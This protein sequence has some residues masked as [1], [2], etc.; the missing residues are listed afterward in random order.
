MNNILDLTLTLRNF[1]E[2]F[3][4]QPIRPKRLISREA[5]LFQNKFFTLA[6]GGRQLLITIRV[7]YGD[8]QK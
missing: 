5:N 4:T 3:L 1:F 7:I 6:A 8:F 2:K